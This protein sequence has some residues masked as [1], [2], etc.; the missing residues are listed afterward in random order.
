MR[1][2]V[3]NRILA[4]L[5]MVALCGPAFVQAQEPRNPAPKKEEAK[6]QELGPATSKTR[7][8]AAEAVK[9]PPAVP[10]LPTAAPVDPKTYV[11]GPE[12]ILLVRVWR[13]S[14]LSGGVQVRPDG[15]ITLPLIGELDAAGLTPE[16]LK[17]KIVEALSEFINKPE[18]LV[19][20]QAVQSK[21]YYIVGGVG[22]PGTFPLVVPLTVLEA[23][24][25]A[26]G[27]REFANTK[28]I[29]ILRGTK[30]L[31]FNWNEVV[32]GKNMQQ[33][34]LIENGDYIVVPE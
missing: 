7:E 16:G 2:V 34:V 22:R 28:K 6:P 1:V 18:V 8:E 27:F 19:S 10:A 13:E 5:L 33:N 17:A 9:T 24:T 26:G 30:I 14:E 12:D 29:T 3:V 15:K 20:L 23:L 25:N 11:I 21:K 4:G 32:K 31:K